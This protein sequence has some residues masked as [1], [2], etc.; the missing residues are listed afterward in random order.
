VDEELVVVECCDFIEPSD[1]LFTED[2]Y[3]LLLG[4]DVISEHDFRKAPAALILFVLA[5][6][7]SV[8]II[9]ECK[10]SL[11]SFVLI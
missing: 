4:N 3:F 6:F 2:R 9:K 10:L 7:V 8:S 5:L 1:R 11:S